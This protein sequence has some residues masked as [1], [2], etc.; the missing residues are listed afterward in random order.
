MRWK[1]DNV[2]DSLKR[3]LL[4]LLFDI[5]MHSLPNGGG[6]L[7]SVLQ[8]KERNIFLILSA[9]WVSSRISDTQ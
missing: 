5:S 3:Q 1:M 7:F 2:C 8:G 9:H 4:S 6:C